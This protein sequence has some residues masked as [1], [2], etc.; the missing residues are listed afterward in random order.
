MFR[1]L[2]ENWFA[3]VIGTGLVGNAAAIL[4]VHVTGPPAAAL[5]VWGT[6]GSGP[7]C[8]DGRLG[9]ALDPAP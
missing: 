6:G 9:R 3:T 8:A 1:D 7:D 5:A 2:G 4:S